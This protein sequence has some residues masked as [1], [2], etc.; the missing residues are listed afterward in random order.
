MRNAWSRSN[1]SDIGSVITFAPWK[2]AR[3]RG[4]CRRPR[5]VARPR[6]FPIPAESRHAG[7]PS[8]PTSEPVQAMFSQNVAGSSTIVEGDT[9]TTAGRDEIGRPPCPAI[10]IPPIAQRGTEEKSNEPD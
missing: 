9:N 8:G 3:V 4:R 5:G 2:E 10:D 1:R 6:S 7:S